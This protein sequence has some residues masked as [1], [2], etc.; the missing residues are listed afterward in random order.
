VVKQLLQ[1][2]IGV[3]DAQL[4][5]GVHLEDLKASDVQDPDEGG[6]RL[7]GTVKG[8]VDSEHNPLE[9]TLIQC[10]CESLGRKLSLEKEG[11]ASVV[12]A[13]TDAVTVL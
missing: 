8:F 6:T 3:V 10:L 4:L 5:K 2:L 9:Q 11:I 7:E 12:T 13:T 1:L